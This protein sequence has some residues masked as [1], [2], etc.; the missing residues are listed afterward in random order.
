MY[1]KYAEG[2]SR[3]TLNMLVN[4]GYLVENPIFTAVLALF[5]CPAPVVSM[6]FLQKIFVIVIASAFHVFFFFYRW[7]I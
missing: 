3:C 2:F 6:T 5:V 1:A 7:E 4:R